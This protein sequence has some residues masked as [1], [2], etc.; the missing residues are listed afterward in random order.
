V[1]VFDEELT[2]CHIADVKTK[3]GLVIEF[4]RSTI[5]PDEV[6]ARQSFYQ[7]MIWVI[8]GSRNEFDRINFSN[9][10]SGVD[11]DGLAHFHWFGR[12]K[13]FDRWHTTKPVFIDFGEK[14]G[15][16]RILRFDPVSRKGLAVL[17][18]IETFVKLASAGTT[19]FDRSG[20][21]ASS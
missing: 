14:F 3:A 20:G 15:F 16:W 10:R 7:R 12:S 5:H 4:Q 2:D 21:P 19:D 18:N 17:T 9:M 8:D 1:P 13:L 11:E 6:D